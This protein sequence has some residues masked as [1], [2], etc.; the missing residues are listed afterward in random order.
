MDTALG[1]SPNTLVLVGL[2][3]IGTWTTRREFTA[4]WVWSGARRDRVADRDRCA[5]RAH[6]H[7]C[8]STAYRRI[9][10]HRRRPPDWTKKWPRVTRCST[11]AAVP[12]RDAW[13]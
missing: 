5:R 12:L 6:Q 10:H 2:R 4:D 1:T 3:C 8:S 9:G 7:R 11:T 13:A